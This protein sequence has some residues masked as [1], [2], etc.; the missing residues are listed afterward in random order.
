MRGKLVT[1][2]PDAL[3]LRKREM[4]CLILKF[5]QKSFKTASHTS[6]PEASARIRIDGS[7]E[8]NQVAR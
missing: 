3:P 7:N 1:L 2:I 8:L 6:S 5:A 4:G